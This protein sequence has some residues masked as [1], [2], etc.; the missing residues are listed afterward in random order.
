MQ[1]SR[2]APLLLRSLICQFTTVAAIV[3]SVCA[4]AGD[5]TGS[6]IFAIPQHLVG[7]G[8]GTLDLRMFTFSGSEIQNTAGSFNGD[9]GNNTLPQGGGA[10]TMS[11]IESYVTTAGDLKNYYNLNFASNS[12]TELVIYLDLNETGGG[13]PTNTLARL[14][15]VLNPTTI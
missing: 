12:I 5:I 2:H 14:D 13:Q 8:N 15:I 4:E 11:F 6:N 9:N 3:G 10:D 1:P 7:S